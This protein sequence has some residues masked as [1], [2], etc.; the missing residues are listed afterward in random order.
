LRYSAG[1]Q[2]RPTAADSDVQAANEEAAARLS[3]WEAAARLADGRLTCETLARSCLA[4]IEQREAA[5]GAWQCFDADRILANAK[6]LD[7][8][9]RHGPLHGLP[10]GV[11]DVIDTRDLPTELGSPIYH[12]RRPAEDADC[13][14][15][16]RAAGALVFGKTVT[17]EF[18]D[19]YAGKTRNPLNPSRTPGGSSSGSAA[20]VADWMV[21][22]AFGTQTGG[23]VNRPASFC[24]VVGYKP[25]YRQHSLSGVRSLAPSMDTL[26]FFGRT[27][28]CVDLFSSALAGGHPAPAPD[29]ETAPSFGVWRM[30]WQ[31]EKV[32][33]AAWQTLDHAIACATAAGA[34]IEELRF[35]AQ[36]DPLIDLQ[37]SLYDYERAR[38]LR[39]EWETSPALLSEPLREGI[40]RG[41]G[42]SDAEADRYRT[43]LAQL[44]IRFADIVA[45]V[46]AVLTPA[47]TGEAPEG[48]SDTGNPLFS[49]PFTVLYGP[50]VS[51]PCWHGPAGLPIGVQ[52]A[53]AFGEDRRTLAAA[54]WLERAITARA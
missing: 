25:S 28:A 4:R 32:S 40:E 14:A 43:E 50:A 21:P 42:I 38:A 36:F 11:K 17:T 12:G 37:V 22:L 46:D 27:V 15:R 13:V 23:S 41:L 31:A 47:A 3:A 34:E 30:A 52:V 9:P 45:D 19:W 44:R 1:G 49:K 5:V 24:G 7:R 26:G 35:P 29:A 48:L 53:G 39:P 20:A 6:A 10:I 16:A 18:A 8:G 51:V 33:R 2:F 54:A